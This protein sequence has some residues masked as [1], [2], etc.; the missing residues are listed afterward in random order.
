VFNAVCAYGWRQGEKNEIELHR[1]LYYPLKADYP[2]LV[3]DLHVQ[4]RV[5]ATETVSSALA[6][7]RKYARERVERK[8]SQPRSA[9]CPPRY[10]V[11]TYRVDGTAARCGFRPPPG[12]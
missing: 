8:V 12:G 9:A 11:H 6:L 7:R 1:A 10:N 4:A 3:S 5:K 2:A